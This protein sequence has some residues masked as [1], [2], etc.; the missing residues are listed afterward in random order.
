MRNLVELKRKKIRIAA[1]GDSNPE[2]NH[3][4][5]GRNYVS[6]RP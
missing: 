6:M 1:F 3:G 5:S 4:T 2:F